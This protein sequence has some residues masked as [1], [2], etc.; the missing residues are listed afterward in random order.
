MKIKI[1]K[2]DLINIKSICTA[3]ETISKRKKQPSGW[4]KKKQKPLANKDTYREFLFNTYKP[5][6]QLNVK[7]Q[8][9]TK[10]NKKTSNPIKNQPKN[11]CTFLQ[12]SHR[13]GHKA[14]ETML[15]I[16]SS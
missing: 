6:V 2:W 11:K 9:K 3:K 7:K 1:N 4:E 15:S 16:T 13:D 10:Q 5:L 8:N 12:R 14:H